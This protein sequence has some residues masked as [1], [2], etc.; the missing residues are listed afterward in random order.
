MGY[1]T[2]NPLLPILYTFKPLLVFNPPLHVSL[3]VDVTFPA[4]PQFLWSDPEILRLM[5]LPVLDYANNQTYKY[6]LKVNYTYVFAPHHLGYWPSECAFAMWVCA[7]LSFLLS[8]A[9]CDLDP[10]RQENMPIEETANLVCHI[11]SSLT[12]PLP[13]LILFSH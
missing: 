13:L 9:V 10:S 2:I 8:F 11:P 12:D 4:S 3:Q 6:G 7:C 1:I 5:I